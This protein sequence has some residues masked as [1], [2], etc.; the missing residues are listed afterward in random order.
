MLPFNTTL[1]LGTS[2]QV[3]TSST[4][5]H[6]FLSF[7]WLIQP[8]PAVIYFTW[9]SL[10]WLNPL[11]HNIYWQPNYVDKRLVAKYKLTSLLRNKILYHLV[12]RFNFQLWQYGFKDAN[13]QG[14]Q[15]YSYITVILTNSD[16]LASGPARDKGQP[17]QVPH[18]GHQL[19]RYSEITCVRVCT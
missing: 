14:V 11:T 7:P 18:S 1:L 6:S 17:S 8:L 13:G 10:F 16:M 15:N 5:F 2:L 12:K 19:H 4:L 3:K 9:P